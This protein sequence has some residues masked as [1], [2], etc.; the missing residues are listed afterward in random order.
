MDDSKWEKH[1]LGQGIQKN[2]ICDW[3]EL[4]GTH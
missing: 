2:Q 1:P 4:F 3:N